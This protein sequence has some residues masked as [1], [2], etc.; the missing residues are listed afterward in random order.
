[1]EVKKFNYM[2]EIDIIR[3]PAQKFLGVLWGAFLL[4]FGSPKRHPDALLA[5]TLLEHCK[6]SFKKMHAQRLC[7]RG[8]AAMRPA[9]H[10]DT[11]NTVF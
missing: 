9:C 2:F 11:Q 1:M 10:L 7:Y 8:L 3:N 6:V 5:K 4:D